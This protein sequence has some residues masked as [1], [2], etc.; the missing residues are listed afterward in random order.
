MSQNIQKCCND[1]KHSSCSIMQA[2]KG[3]VANWYCEYTKKLNV[4]D[5][6]VDPKLAITPPEWCPLANNGENNKLT[7]SDK[8]TMLGKFTPRTAW[9]DIKVNTVYR[10]PALPNTKRRDIL[11]TSKLKYSCQYVE[12]IPNQRSTSAQTLLENS[13]IARFMV[14]HRNMEIEVKKK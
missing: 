9:D 8:I 14:E 5:L 4:I 2:S 1:C 13:L 10:V 7:L 12:L 11:I 3:R 6:S